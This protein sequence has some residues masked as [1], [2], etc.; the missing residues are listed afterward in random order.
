MI[1]FDYSKL[2]GLI[3]EK[4]GSQSALA[5][6]IPISENQLSAYMTGNKRFTT[7]KIDRIA[8]LLDIKPEE[9]GVY[10]FTPKVR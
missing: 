10:F 4:Y 6:E 9:I 7:K 8:A 1:E 3:V 5:A 2:K